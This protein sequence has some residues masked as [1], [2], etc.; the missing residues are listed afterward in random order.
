MARGGD[1]SKAK[2]VSFSDSRQDA[3][4]SALDVERFRH[5]DVIREV[6]FG[7]LRLA[8]HGIQNGLPDEERRLERRKRTLKGFLEELDVGN[9]TPPQ[10]LLEDIENERAEVQKLERKIIQARAGIVPLSEIVEVTA[11]RP[12]AKVLPFLTRLLELGIHPYDERGIKKVEIVSLMVH[13]WMPPGSRPNESKEGIGIRYRAI[14]AWR[15]RA[16]PV[17][18]IDK[19][20]SVAVLMA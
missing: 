3:A 12:E 13:S 5:Q 10:D 20:A 2:L 7:E 1:P 14:A 16:K 4:R 11:P 17:S 8:A 6:L 19:K 15:L 18:A 9:G